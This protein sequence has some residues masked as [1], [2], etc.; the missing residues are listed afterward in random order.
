MNRKV[1]LSL[2]DITLFQPGSCFC[3]R[4]TIHIALERG[5]G[6]SRLYQVLGFI[7]Q[8]G[9]HRNTLVNLEG[10]ASQVALVVKNLPARAGDIREKHGF[11]P[12][13]GKI[14]WRRAWPSTLVFLSGESHG[15]RN[16]G[17]TVHGVAKSWT[18]LSD[19]HTHTHTHTI[20]ILFKRKTTGPKWHYL[21]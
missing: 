9:C 15:Q 20:Y 21:C 19:S 13:V 14:P 2:L 6:L 11:S 3:R 17:A 5:P 7:L 18:Q 1:V 4:M 10:W 16:L 8:P 12:W